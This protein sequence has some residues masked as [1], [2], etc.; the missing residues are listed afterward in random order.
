MMRKIV[1]TISLFLI[2]LSAFAQSLKDEEGRS[3]KDYYYFYPQAEIAITP[4]NVI[5]N[6]MKFPRSEFRLDKN[7]YFYVKDYIV[8]FDELHK[9]VALHNTYLNY[10]QVTKEQSVSY[11][12]KAHFKPSTYL[13][14]TLKSGKVWYDGSILDRIWKETVLETDHGSAWW[15]SSDVK[16]HTWNYEHLPWVAGGKGIGESIDVSFESDVGVLSFLNGYVDPLH[17]DYF[18]KNARVKDM[19]VTDIDNDKDYYFTLSDSVKVKNFKLENATKHIKVTIES[20]YKGE[21]YDDVCL[22]MI[23]GLIDADRLYPIVDRDYAE[24]YWRELAGNA[25]TS[26][27]EYTDGNSPVFERNDEGLY[28][29]YI[30]CKNRKEYGD[31]SDVIKKPHAIYD[32]DYLKITLDNSD[33]RYDWITFWSKEPIKAYLFVGKSYAGMECRDE[34]NWSEPERNDSFSETRKEG[35]WIIGKNYSSIAWAMILPVSVEIKI[36]YES[37]RKDT[38]VL[39]KDQLE[40]LKRYSE[41]ALSYGGYK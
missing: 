13:S 14:E 35:S 41:L 29:L 20:V 3:L 18:K 6:Q 40:K 21:K 33:E 2:T 39:N 5:F 1:F 30:D 12:V 28:E 10:K 16:L 8:I 17:P 24:Q 23:S 25:S 4:D 34:L 38:I 36:L 11:G 26:Y 32:T 31:N 7:G 27:S 15:I 22:S 9:L 37:G 19:K